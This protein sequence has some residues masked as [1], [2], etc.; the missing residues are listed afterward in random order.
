MDR[1]PESNS[2]PALVPAPDCRTTQ[3]L[4]AE[5]V[6]DAP[7]LLREFFPDLTPSQVTAVAEP[8]GINGQSSVDKLYRRTLEEYPNCGVRND[9]GHSKDACPAKNRVSYNCDVTGHYGRVCRKSKKPA[10]TDWDW[11]R[12]FIMTGQCLWCGVSRRRDRMRR[13]RIHTHGSCPAKEKKCFNCGSKGHF[14]RVCQKEKIKAGP[15]K[16]KINASAKETHVGDTATRVSKGTQNDE[17]GDKGWA[18]TMDPRGAIQPQAGTVDDVIFKFGARASRFQDI[19]HC[20]V[21]RHTN[22]MPDRSGF[23]LQRL[24]VSGKPHLATR[25]DS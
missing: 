22:E 20:G 16:E 7:A 3:G 18:E 25:C 4:P 15:K 8:N 12:R 11:Y 2:A 19:W 24:A 1:R 6:V 9:K 17:K 10:R 14:W 21:P 5:G 13:D 23:F